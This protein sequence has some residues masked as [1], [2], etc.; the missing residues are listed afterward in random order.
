MAYQITEEEYKEIVLRE[1]QTRDKRISKR[2]R[3]LMLRYEGKSN[4]E[5]AAKLDISTD[6]LS[7]LIRAEERT[8][9]LES[10][11]QNYTAAIG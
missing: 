8:S 9:V 6:R 5:I 4:P 3:V 7:H 2:L 1:K 11:R 10:L